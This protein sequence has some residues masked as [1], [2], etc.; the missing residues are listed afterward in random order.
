MLIQTNN[1]K[2]YCHSHPCVLISYS[3]HAKAYHL[4]DTTDG[5]IFN[6]FHITFVEHLDQL[7]MDLLP[8]TTISLEPDT[9]P[10][11]D[12]SPL[13]TSPSPTFDSLHMIH[14]H[15]ENHLN[16]MPSSSSFSSLPSKNHQNVMLIAPVSPSPSENCLKVMPPSISPFT[17]S[18][19]L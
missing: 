6:L 14:S 19:N 8:E 7:E 5:S 2:I 12:A 9:S 3:P 13:P 11:W 17:N 4:W 10:T 16:V 18:S 1:P 15:G